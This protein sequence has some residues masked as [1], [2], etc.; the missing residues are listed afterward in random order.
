M[1]IKDMRM[2]NTDT[3]NVGGEEDPGSVDSRL[4]LDPNDERWSD[5][6]ADWEDGAEYSITLRVRQ[7]S[8]GEYEILEAEAEEM[9]EG[10][11]E[12]LEQAEPVEDVTSVPAKT[13]RSPRTA[14]ARASRG[15][16]KGLTNP[17]VIGLLG[18]RR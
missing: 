2:D 15:V 4:S 17:A 8:P 16:T 1:A 10:G 6:I 7:M 13:G 3:G 12:E 5:S 9:E 18:K 14:Q 11:D